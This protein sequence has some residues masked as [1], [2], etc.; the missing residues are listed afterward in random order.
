VSSRLL[1]NN[2]RELLCV[3]ACMPAMLCAPIAFAQQQQP[4]LPQDDVIRIKV[5]AVSVRVS[6]MDA[7]GRPITGLCKS[8]FRVLDN[9]VERPLTGFDESNDPAQI[10]F[11]VESSPSV[12]FLRK[13]YLAAAQGLVAGLSPADR[14]AVVSYSTAPSLVLGFTP[15]KQLALAALGGMQVDYVKGYLDLNLSSSLQ[16]TLGWLNSLPGE[17]TIV[18]ISS[19][20]DASVKEREI[21][22]RKLE[23]SDTRVLAVSSLSNLRAT[24]KEAKRS[25]LSRQDQVWLQ[26]EFATADSSLREVAAVTGGSVYF[27]RTAQDLNHALTAIVQ[28]TRQDYLLTFDP[29]AR[30]GQVHSIEVKV[31]HRAHS[32][33]YR[34]AYLAPPPAN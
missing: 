6:V 11:L 22:E 17:K 15:D 24:P 28:L 5:D 12:Y 25:G 2:L 10:V 13:A 3:A 7:K 26:G 18:L 23:A 32:V 9:H 29:A 1:R 21:L 20:I 14:I 19:G 27:P 16:M 33:T 8:D 34:R 31:N 30:D 4:P